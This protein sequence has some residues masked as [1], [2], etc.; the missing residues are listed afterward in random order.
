MRKATVLFKNEEAGILSQHDDGSFTFRYYDTWVAEN[1]K[2]SISPTLPIAEREFQSNY[3]FP[4][5]YS[6]LPEGSNKHIVCTL[7][8]ID[9]DDHFGLLMLTA[10]HDSIGAIRIIKMENE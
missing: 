6:L 3:L 8:R 2:T 10:K 1:N 9:K 4:F 5:F 7:N